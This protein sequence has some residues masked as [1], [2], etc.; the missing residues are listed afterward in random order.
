MTISPAAI[1]CDLALS[2]GRLA[3]ASSSAPHVN[4]ER[5]RGE[6]ACDEVTR[7]K[8]STLDEN[9]RSIAETEY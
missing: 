9:V 5:G 4:V 7:T 8:A 3:N 1:R 2:S 6:D